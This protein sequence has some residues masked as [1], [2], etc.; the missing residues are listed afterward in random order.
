MITRML[1]LLAA[2][3]VV[4]GMFTAAC[5]DD[6]DED[7]PGTLPGRDEAVAACQD[8]CQQARKNGAYLEDGP[9]LWEGEVD[10]WVCDVAHDPRT[11]VDNDPANQC[12]NYKDPYEHFVEVDPNTCNA[13]NVK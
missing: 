4:A 6:D 11:E 13:F 12:P 3:L 9:C 8:A 5:D 1:A 10:D 2:L 7:Q